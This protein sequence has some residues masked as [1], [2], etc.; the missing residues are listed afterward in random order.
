MMLSVNDDLRE[1]LEDDNDDLIFEVSRDLEIER[2]WILIYEIWL[3][4][5]SGDDFDDEGQ[6]F[7][8]ERISKRL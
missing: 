4:E 2:E 8:N 6:R 3:D 5:Y 1:D 7:V